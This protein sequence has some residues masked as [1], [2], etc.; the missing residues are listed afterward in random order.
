MVFVVAGENGIRITLGS[1]I[2]DFDV[3]DTPDSVAFS[4]IENGGRLAP[5]G[6]YR[7]FL[8]TNVLI[9][10]SVSPTSLSDRIHLVDTCIMLT[11]CPLLRL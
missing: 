7:S 4:D 6:K 9:P 11:F 5:A 2:G 8:M 3:L 1:N 10:G